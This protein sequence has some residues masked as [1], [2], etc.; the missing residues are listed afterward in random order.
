[1][2]WLRLKLLGAAFF[3][4]VVCATIAACADSPRVAIVSSDGA[5]RTVVNVEI[6]N[7]PSER[8]L[9]LMYRQHLDADAGL[10][11][12]FPAVDHL[13]FWMK[14]TEIPLDMI[15]ADG[16]GKILG[17]VENATP[18]TENS[19]SVEGDSLY[20]LEVN[21]GFAKRYHLR[22]GDRLKFMSFVPKAAE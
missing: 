9:G 20:V 7:T 3:G 15:F 22:V 21:G 1:M 8:E 5:I 17:V 2:N 18:Y 13:T 10:L 14:N 19:R 4:V 12:V 16:D 6:A 11:F